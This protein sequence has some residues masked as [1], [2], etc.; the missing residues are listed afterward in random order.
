MDEQAAPI[1][2]DIVVHGLFFDQT[3]VPVEDRVALVKQSFAT[4]AEREKV[5]LML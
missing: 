4:R 1:V 3:K 5:Y 2:Q